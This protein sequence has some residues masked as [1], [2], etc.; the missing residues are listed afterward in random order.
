MSDLQKTIKEIMMIRKMRIFAILQ[1]P[2]DYTLA[3]LRNIYQPRGVDFAFIKGDSL[4]GKSVVEGAIGSL[5]LFNQIRW[6][7]DHLRRYDAFNLN[8]YTGRI[9]F[10][11]I[12]LNIVFFHKPFSIDSDTELRIPTKPVKKFLKWLWLHLIF[13]R[14]Y[15]YGFAGGNYGHKDLFRHYGMPE[16]NIWLAPMLVENSLFANSKSNRNSKFRFGY[17]GRLVKIKQ[18]DKII[19]AFS[20]LNDGN[21]ELVIIGDGIMREELERRFATANIRF[22]GALFGEEKIREMQ[23]LDCL[24][25]YS[26]HEEWGLVVNEAL[27]CGVPVLVSD[28][29]GARKDLVE[30]ETP[31][32]LVAKWDDTSDLTAKMDQIVSDCELWCRL[33]ANSTKRMNEWDYRLYERQYDSWLQDL[34]MK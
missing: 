18:V 34:G 6:L 27:A 20:N 29:V 2:A 8:G 26:E 30:G 33:H 19:E 21:T 11:F 28:R 3:L 17:V 7:I 14:P 10:L 23:A 32:G 24:V 31:T 25:L 4:V 9:C 5:S 12:V 16:K 22:A 15:C 13:T 1:S